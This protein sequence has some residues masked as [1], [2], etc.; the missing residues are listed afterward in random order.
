MSI[1]ICQ[2]CN[3]A[4]DTDFNAEDIND[5]GICINCIEEAECE[6]CEG[7]G[8]VPCDEFDEDSKQYMPGVGEQVCVCQSI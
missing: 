1:I 7:E 5:D 4:I 3:A 6:F 8:V 2:S